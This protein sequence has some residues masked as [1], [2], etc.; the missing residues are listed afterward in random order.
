MVWTDW[1]EVEGDGMDFDEILYD[2]KHHED[3]GG[4]IARIT[5][6]KPE[7]YNA[8]AISMVEEMFRA[9]YDANHDPSIGVVIVAGAGKH[10]G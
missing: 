8:M 4:G 2:K 10:F 9:F 6:N 3:L 1:Q 5:M 7:K